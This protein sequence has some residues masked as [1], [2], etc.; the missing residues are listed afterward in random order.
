MADEKLEE[1]IYYEQ[2]IGN[3]GK[4]INIKVDENP[5]NFSLSEMMFGHESFYS[6]IY[7]PLD[8]IKYIDKG[9]HLIVLK[10]KS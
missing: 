3:D 7:I 6:N 1:K 5:R 9:L 2:I 4:G 10:N 8:S